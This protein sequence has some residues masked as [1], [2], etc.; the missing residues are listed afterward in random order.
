MPPATWGRASMNETPREAARRLAHPW[1][2]QGYAPE[3]LHVYKDEDGRPCYWRIRAKH[4]D[5]GDKIIRPMRLNSC[6]YELREPEFLPAGK[7]LYNLDKIA[8]TPDAP[9]WI[10]EGE[11]A[12]DV[13]TKLGVVATTSG[14]AQSAA[15]ADWMPLRGRECRLW[16][17]NDDAGQAY[18]G[19]VAA[20]LQGLGC[21]LSAVDVDALGLPPKGDA[22]DWMRAHPGATLADLEAIKRSAAR[23]GLEDASGHPAQLSSATGGDLEGRVAELARLPAIEYDRVRITEAAR[24][25]IRAGTLDSEV[26]RRRAEVTV[27]ASSGRELQLPKREPWTEP[28]DGS[29][30]LTELVQS[31]RRY[32]V[33]TPHADA[34]LALWVVFTFTLDAASAAPVLAITSPE[35]RCGKT[36][37]LSWLNELVRAPLP[38]ANVSPAALYRSIEKWHPTLLIDEADSFLRDN[39]ELR[40]I[41]NSGHT[42][43]TAYVIRTV[44]DDHEPRQ[45]STWGAKAIALIGSLPDTLADRAIAVEMQRKMPSERVHKLRGRTELDTLDRLARQCARFATDNL[46]ALEHADPEIPERLND[47]AADSWAP[48]LAIADA[49]GGR[50]P[51][52]ARSAASVLCSASPDGD[53]RKTELLHDVQQIFRRKDIDRLA[54]EELA[55]ELAAD[56][57]RP[58]ATFNRGKQITERQLAKLLRP[59]GI[60]SRSVRFD[61]APS[62]KGYTLD[63]FEDAFA[64]YLPPSDPSHRHNPRQ[65]SIVTD[66]ASVTNDACDGSLSA[67]QPAPVLA[68]DG[69]T[70]RNTGEARGDANA[71]NWERF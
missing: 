9:V 41:L 26:E 57:E 44:G 1:I 70:D 7:P 39:E 59:F 25:G 34:A 37:L 69:V 2:A 49:A 15:A 51:E 46:A 21:K 45:F 18:M 6:G 10:C 71:A 47:R 56:P 8:A 17:D 68:C 27:D 3:A 65:C 53:S 40:G 64:R 12:A 42:R 32:L 62:A 63:R 33:L 38:A 11:K 35:K 22:A 29:A 61:S 36:T 20:I 19:E 58:W 24:L 67:S 23:T 52:I 54:S 55:R 28:V 60:T 31:T 48:L 5:T 43:G 4:P 13:L 50:W 14:G 66:K 30:L 16:P